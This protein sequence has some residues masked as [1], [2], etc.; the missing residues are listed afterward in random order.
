MPCVN[1]HDSHWRIRTLTRHCAPPPPSHPT[2]PQVG[3]SGD[4]AMLTWNNMAYQ[5]YFSATAANVGHAFIS[6]DIE[7]PA[8]DPELYTRW[9]QIGSFSGVMRSHDRGARARGGDVST[10]L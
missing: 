4:V 8:W 3:F 9:L 10:K 6:H 7:G 1:L 2:P 5:P